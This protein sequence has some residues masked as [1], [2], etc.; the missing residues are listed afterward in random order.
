MRARKVGET[1]VQRNSAIAVKAPQVDYWALN[2]G[3]GARLDGKTPTKLKDKEGNEVDIRKL[4][5]EA[6]AKRLAASSTA[7]N[8]PVHGNTLTGKAAPIAEET[9]KPQ[10]LVSKRKSRVG[11]KY[12]RLKQSGNCAFEGA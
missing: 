7:A 1:G 5:A 3:D 9:K 2:A 10:T 11:S 6:A 12:S 8:M 4:R